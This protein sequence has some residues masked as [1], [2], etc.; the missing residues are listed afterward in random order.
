MIQTNNLPVS[1]K[2]ETLSNVSLSSLELRINKIEALLKDISL[3]K[4]TDNTEYIT[5]F[6]EFQSYF[7]KVIP[8]I[9]KKFLSEKS[10]SLTDC[11]K[12]IYNLI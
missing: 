12:S 5:N 7:L 11:F 2:S 8:K 10:F 3:N 6:N 1:P 9:F 4:K